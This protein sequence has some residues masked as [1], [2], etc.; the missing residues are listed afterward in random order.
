MNDTCTYDQA[1]Q[2]ASSGQPPTEGVR[3]PPGL[4]LGGLDTI[5]EEPDSSD[6]ETLL[7]LKRLRADVDE[8][9]RWKN[10]ISA[11]GLVIEPPTNYENSSVQPPP[12]PPIPKKFP[13]VFSSHGD[14]TAPFANGQVNLVEEV[15]IANFKILAQ[16][17]APLNPEKF[18]ANMNLNDTFVNKNALPTFD[19]SNSGMSTFA[20]QI[21]SSFDFSCSTATAT[22]A[23]QS[24]FPKWEPTSRRKFA[25]SLESS[26]KNFM[27]S[28]AKRS[29]EESDEIPVVSANLL[30]D[31]NPF[32]VDLDSD[33]D[34]NRNRETGPPRQ[35]PPPPPRVSPAQKPWHNLM[36]PEECQENICESDRQIASRIERS[37]SPSEILTNNNSNETDEEHNLRLFN[38]SYSVQK[39]KSSIVEGSTNSGVSTSVKTAKNPPPLPP[40]PLTFDFNSLSIE[41]QTRYT[42]WLDVAQ[43][44][45]SFTNDESLA[46]NGWKSFDD[47]GVGV[48]ASTLNRDVNG[49]NSINHEMKRADSP[50]RKIKAKRI[51]HAR[52]EAGTDFCQFKAYRK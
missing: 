32:K 27:Q 4:S 41:E 11:R 14:K 43:Y 28:W 13:L 39:S 35:P 42:D 30:H 23:F 21:P 10:M 46:R 34:F 17:K 47:N 51:L 26:V 29:S 22:L 38:E 25:E 5:V 7:A 36:E 45:N 2:I 18:D 24:S 19:W 40:R 48:V 6:I 20:P 33:V 8:L 16:L 12:I 52:P 37:L 1:C 31:S 15:P 3:K 50:K 44:T 9:L 49:A